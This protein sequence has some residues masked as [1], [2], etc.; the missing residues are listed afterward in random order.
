[1]L[2]RKGRRRGRGYPGDLDL[3]AEN[4]SYACRT[5][6]SCQFIWSYLFCDLLAVSVPSLPPRR[7]HLPLPLRG[8]LVLEVLLLLL[9]ELRGP[10]HLVV[11]LVL[12][13]IELH[14][15]EVG[16]SAIS[17]NLVAEILRET[18]H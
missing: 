2:R 15:A 10:G 16:L 6:L 9:M 13:V 14:L 18:Y 4:K 11:E 3:H 5:M 8:S 12:V 1:M 7:D 17:D